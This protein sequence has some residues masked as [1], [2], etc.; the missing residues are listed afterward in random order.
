VTDKGWLP[1]SRQIGLTGRSVGPRLYVAI[2]LS[3]K[4]NHIVGVSGAGQILAI[5]SDPTAP[6]FDGADV[7]IVAD[8]RDAVPMLVQ[9]LTAS[10]VAISRVDQLGRQST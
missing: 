6:V 5:N 2:G 8:W 9:A 10:A 1:R 7:G 3:G 4:F